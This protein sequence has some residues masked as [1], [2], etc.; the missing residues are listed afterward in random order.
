M[1]CKYVTYSLKWYINHTF[2]PL[3]TEWINEKN[4]MTYVNINDKY[5][6]YM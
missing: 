6:E 3:M 5:N 4:T 2:C 1:T